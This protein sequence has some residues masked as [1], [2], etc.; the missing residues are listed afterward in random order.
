MSFATL[1]RQLGRKDFETTEH[2]AHDLFAALLDGGVPDLEMGAILY[3]L[4]AKG[5]SLTEL[6]GFQRAIDARMYHLDPPDSAVLPVVIPAYGSV[7][8][9]PNMLPLLALLLARFGVP[10][11]LHGTLENHG[12]MAAAYVLRELD[13]MPCSTLNQAQNELASR[14]IAFVPTATLCPGL[15][16]L[17]ILRSRLGLH[18]SAHFMVKLLDPF[19]GAS[20]RLVSAGEAGFLSRLNEFIQATPGSGLLFQSTEG[21]AFANPLQRPKIDLIR[22]G[23]S[24][25]LFDSEHSESHTSSSWPSANNVKTT[26]AWIKQ[27]LRG[28]AP[29]PLPLANQLAC[30]LY[31]AGYA[32]DFNQAKAIVAVETGCMA[33]A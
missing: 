30:C 6:M 14:Q 3:A 31:G 23:E 1:L 28:E 5:E 25:T 26:A 19:K 15:S 20:L 2:E 9:M 22:D 21:E 18:N 10:V 8:S 7:V 24:E 33:T 11:L 4:R 17:L 29:L 12:G 16:S 13:V 32:Q 27:V